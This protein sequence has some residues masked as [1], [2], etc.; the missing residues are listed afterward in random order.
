MEALR[1]LRRLLIV[2]L[3]LLHAGCQNPTW[4]QQPVF[5]EAA[6]TRTELLNGGFHPATH[7]NSQIPTD[8]NVLVKKINDTVAV[9]IFEGEK[10]SKFCIQFQLRNMDT[11]AI[12][13]LLGRLGFQRELNPKNNKTYFVNKS[14]ELRYEYIVTPAAF[15]FLD[16]MLPEKTDFSVPPRD[17]VGRS[18]K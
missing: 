1:T 2:F 14:K 7:R 8:N 6:V 15:A 9:Y 18:P 11:S 16:A 17:S 13:N 3:L 5:F 12:L 10:V 4:G